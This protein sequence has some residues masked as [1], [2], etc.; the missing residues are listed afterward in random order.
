MKVSY[1]ESSAFGQKREADNT[2]DS[3]Q[4]SESRGTELDSIKSE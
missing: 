2:Y 1:F 3:F 4:A